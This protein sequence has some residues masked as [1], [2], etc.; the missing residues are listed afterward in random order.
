MT[1]Q[2]E[3]KSVFFHGV[4]SDSAIMPQFGGHT[5]K[6]MNSTNWICW[7][8]LVGCLFLVLG[9]VGTVKYSENTVHGTLKA[10][11]YFKNEKSLYKQTIT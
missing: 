10:L 2:G 4:A 7:G 5:F 3:G 1:T 11:I 9:G 8:F 6:S